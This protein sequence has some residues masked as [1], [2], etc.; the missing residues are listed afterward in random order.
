MGRRD[1]N[2]SNVLSET[3]FSYTLQGTQSSLPSLYTFTKII[4]S[5]MYTNLDTEVT[6]RRQEVT[7]QNA[8]L[9]QPF[10]NILYTYRDVKISIDAW[11]NFI[12]KC[13]LNG[14][15]VVRLGVVKRAAHAQIRTKDAM[16]TSAVLPLKPTN[17]PHN[18]GTLYRFLGWL[19]AY[20]S[21]LL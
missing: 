20:L 4:G 9:S 6:L 19:W 14:S 11:N 15:Q 17:S 13:L 2:G 8:N 7:S 5:F 12:N 18:I 16:L 21:L 10:N 1:I 3:W